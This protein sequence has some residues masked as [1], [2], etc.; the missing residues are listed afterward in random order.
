MGFS[1][2]FVTICQTTRRHIRNN[3]IL[4][5]SRVSASDVS[6]TY[7]SGRHTIVENIVKD[8]LSLAGKLMFMYGTKGTA[9]MT[10]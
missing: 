9:V 10:Q 1:E 5:I 3:V 7:R 2:K 6:I 4:I 8:S